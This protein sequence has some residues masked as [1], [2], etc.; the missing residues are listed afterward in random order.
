M[1]LTLEVEVKR[2][3]Q[4]W[5]VTDVYYIVYVLHCSM[6]LTVVVIWELLCLLPL[7]FKECIPIKIEWNCSNLTA[8]KGV[9]DIPLICVCDEYLCYSFSFSLFRSSNFSREARNFFA[10]FG[11]FWKVHICTFSNLARIFL[12]FSLKKKKP[13]VRSSFR[14]FSFASL[15][16]SPGETHY[17]FLSYN[18]W[19][20]DVFGSAWFFYMSCT[21]FCI[22][23][24]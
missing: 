1:C 11:V 16:I 21:S 13:K 9:S 19:L 3:S 23:F 5:L 6:C 8:K 2:C 10:K 4:K 15:E 20:V 14:S 12:N 18:L 24:T 17:G 7:F 22:I